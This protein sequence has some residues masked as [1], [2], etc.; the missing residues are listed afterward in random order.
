[1]TTPA[2]DAPLVFPSV[3]FRPVRLL[4]VC[5]ALTALAL[6][7]SGLTGN[8]FFGAFFGL[9]LGLGLVNALLVRRAVEA[10]T[11]ED[12]PLKKKMAVNSATRLLVITAVALTVAFVFREHGGIAVLFGLAIFQALLVMSTS[13]PV[14][15]KIRSDGLNVLDTDSKD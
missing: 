4:I 3:A 2:Q 8:I 7:A 1:M 6:L 12:H 13:I 10:I 15:R 11:A 5:V 14:L 9:G